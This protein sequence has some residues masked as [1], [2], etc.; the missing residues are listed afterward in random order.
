MHRSCPGQSTSCAYL[1][2]GK[3]QPASRAMAKACHSG[4]VR[5]GRNRKTRRRSVSRNGQTRRRSVSRNGQTRRRSASKNGQ[6]R[7]GALRGTAVQRLFDSDLWIP[8]SAA[9]PRN[10]GL[11]SGFRVWLCAPGMTVW[12]LDSGFRNAA[13]EDGRG[14]S[15]FL[16][17]PL[18]SFAPFAV[19]MLSLAGN[20]TRPGYAP[21]AWTKDSRPTSPWPGSPART[22]RCPHT[23][24]ASWSS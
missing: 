9:R 1:I 6:T 7:R 15:L 20:I 19:K 22:R 13:P 11:A 3:A 24:T 16:C 23:G 4:A 5:E 18:R 17:A 8:G 14:S 10:D 21:A 12:F 2:G